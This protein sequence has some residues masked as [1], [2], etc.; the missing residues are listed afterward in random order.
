M[1]VCVCVCVSSSP[2]PLASQGLRLDYF[3]CPKALIPTRTPAK[4][5]GEGEGEGKDEGTRPVLD[6]PEWSHP[7]VR[8][9]F[10]LLEGFG[11]GASAAQMTPSDHCPV[12][13]TLSF[14]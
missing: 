5:E 13:L 4:G 7:V 12:G 2:T 8:E 3:V 6:D 14:D 1:C 10:Q 11:G 9:T